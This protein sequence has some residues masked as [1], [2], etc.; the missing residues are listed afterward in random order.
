MAKWSHDELVELAALLRPLLFQNL[1]PMTRE[2]LGDPPTDTDLDGEFG[3]PGDVSDTA[4]A[5]V[6]VMDDNAA[7]AH[8]RHIITNGVSWWYSAKYTKAV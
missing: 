4:Q 5:F 8:I 6:G 3:D 1:V 7:D 2:N